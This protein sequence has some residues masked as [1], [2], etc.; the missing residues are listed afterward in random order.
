MNRFPTFILFAAGVAMLLA[1]PA[2]GQIYSETFPVD[3]AFPSAAYPEWTFASDNPSV[4][5]NV[6]SGVLTVQG[7]DD[8]ARASTVIPL[9]PQVKIAA[10]VSSTGHSFG[11]GNVGLRWGDLDSLFH[12]GFPGGAF[13]ID[14]N[15]GANNIVGN[16]NM[17]FTP[18]SGRD[19]RITVGAERHAL[20]TE[21]EVVITDGSNTFA[22]ST[23]TIPNSQIE[24][25]TLVGLLLANDGT[26][27]FDN[28]LVTPEPA[29]ATLGLAGLM[30][31][32]LGMRRRGRAS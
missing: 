7:I 11:Q 31:L 25:F 20:N 23:F 3:G 14:E 18:V 6:V 1:R 22:P 10:T 8:G 17:G 15:A 19:Y 9:L 24:D 21:F 4:M 32:G 30:V 12:P 28:F 13:R 5:A 16:T 26:K 27:R 2:S 29:S